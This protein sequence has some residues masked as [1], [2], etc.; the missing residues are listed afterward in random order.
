MVSSVRMPLSYGPGRNASR[1]AVPCATQRA[2]RAASTISGP[3][4]AAGPGIIAL[5]LCSSPPPFTPSLDGFRLLDPRP[6]AHETRLL[7]QRARIHAHGRAGRARMHAAHV[8]KAVAE[9][10]LDGVARRLW[11]R[12]SV[13]DRG[14]GRPAVG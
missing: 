7:E 6:D 4:R 1:A 11:G 9:V 10:A 5:R 12:E 3:R 8:G 13:L 14:I 2:P